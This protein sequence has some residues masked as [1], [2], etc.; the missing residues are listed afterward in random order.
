M[1]NAS[2]GFPSVPQGPIVGP[3]GV[4][5]PIW[6][7]FFVALWNRTGQSSGTPSLIL[8]TISQQAGAMLYRAATAWQ[9]LAPGARYK[10]LRM[11]VAFPEWDT[12]DGNSFGNQNQNTF[13]AGPLTIAGIPT[14]RL[15]GTSDLINTRGQYP[16]SATND[17]ASNGNIGEFIQSSVASGSAVALTSTVT[18]DITSITLTAGDWD[19]W[20]NIATDPAA[21]TTTSVVQ[22]W[23]NT[24]SKTDPGAPNGG[25][26][27]LQQQ[28]I[29]AGLSQIMPVGMMRLSVPTAGATAY[30]SC[31]LTFASSTMA[32]YG[33]IQARRA[34]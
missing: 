20:A 28:A 29:G 15:I 25:A 21:G 12:L 6:F 26:Y 4:P 10:V 7:Q 9:G 31:N 5:T 3:G 34:R 11:G 1:G 16:G 8:D 18:D 13:L 19:V 2:T 27:L 33:S 32:A 22:A 23:I 30:L 17:N 14:F 24:A